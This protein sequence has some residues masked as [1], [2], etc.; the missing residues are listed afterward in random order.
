MYRSRFLSVNRFLAVGF[1]SSVRH[2]EK[3]VAP[4]I[5]GLGRHDASRPGLTGLAGDDSSFIR[6]IPTSFYGTMNYQ[7]DPVADWGWVPHYVTNSQILTAQ[8]LVSPPAAVGRRG[9]WNMIRLIRPSYTKSDVVVERWFQ[10]R[11]NVGSRLNGS[12]WG[13]RYM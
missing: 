5:I 6:V 13:P 12:T 10:R 3:F 1:N 9:I 7:H 2:P 4:P 8:W 11:T